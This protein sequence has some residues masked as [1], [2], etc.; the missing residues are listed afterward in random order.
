M[1]Q[2][3]PLTKKKQLST[4]YLT[5]LRS[6]VPTVISLILHYHNL[7][8]VNEGF[9]KNKN[10]WIIG[11][12]AYEILLNP[13]TILRLELSENNRRFCVRTLLLALFLQLYSYLTRELSFA[14]LCK[15]RWINA[16]IYLK[17]I[18]VGAFDR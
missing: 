11:M 15:I 18:A 7:L 16:N 17:K 5:T 6:N 9:R 10:N 13:R 1:L 3:K 4:H 2:I 8:L 14:K 12:G